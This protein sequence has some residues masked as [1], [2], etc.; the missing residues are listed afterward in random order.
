MEVPQLH[1]AFSEFGSLEGKEIMRRVALPYRTCYSR[2]YSEAPLPGD[3]IATHLAQQVKHSHPLGG[4]IECLL[5]CVQG[6]A[7]NLGEVLFA[8]GSTC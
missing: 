3:P 4:S 5:L 6:G 7:D 2:T 1:L 8:S